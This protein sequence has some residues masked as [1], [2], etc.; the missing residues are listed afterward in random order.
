[1][2]TTAPLGLAAVDPECIAAVEDTARLLESLGH[3]VDDAAPAALDDGALLETFT[4]VMLS[5][6]RADLAEVGELIGRAGHRR[7]RGTVDVGAATK[8]ARAID[9]GSYVGALKK[10][11]AWSRAARSRG[12]STT[13][14]TSCSRPRARSRRRCSATSP[15]RRPARS[16]LLPFAIF[17]APFNVT[18]QPAMSVPL[19][20]SADAVCPSACNSS[21]RRTAKTSCSALAAQLEQAR[22]WADRRPSVHA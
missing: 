14:S 20:T 16:R 6:L 1:M 19:A 11:Q 7:R 13:A 2:R 22:P 4:A 10:M 15:T 18:G 9:A 5:S 17:T 12:G 21:A 3:T 8:P